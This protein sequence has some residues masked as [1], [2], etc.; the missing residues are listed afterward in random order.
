MPYTGVTL[1][2]D[3][4][5]YD[6]QG[7][8]RFPTFYIDNTVTLNYYQSGVVTTGAVT[9]AQ[10]SDGITFSFDIPANTVAVLSY[11]VNVS[12]FAPLT[13]GF[14]IE[15]V[16]TLS[17]NGIDT[18]LKDT[19]AIPIAEQVNLKIAKCA[20]DVATEGQPFTFKFIVSNYGNVAISDTDYVV[21]SDLLNPALSNVQVYANGVLWTEGNQYVYDENLFYFQTQYG[22]I[23]LDAATFT[24]D[25]FGRWITDPSSLVIT[26]T[27]T[28][29]S[30]PPTQSLVNVVPAY[31]DGREASLNVVRIEND[32]YLLGRTG[33]V[34]ASFM[35][36]SAPDCVLKLVS[37]SDPRFSLAGNVV[38]VDTDALT[39]T[40]TAFVRVNYGT[41][42]NVQLDYIP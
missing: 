4:G 3:L 19:Y 22:A 35:I 38:T 10:T 33:D 42:F 14:F 29:Q 34:P 11:E 41:G 6:F 5:K 12:S 27:G 9:A 16:A 20:E 40:I 18:P 21:V 25:S 31:A 32:S 8:P 1:L 39:N 26:I 36:T 17:G 24:Q 23:D 7:F 37:G 2:D 30:Q 13:V 28:V 15:N